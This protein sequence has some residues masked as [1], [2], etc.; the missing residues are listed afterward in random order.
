MSRKTTSTDAAVEKVLRYKAKTQEKKLNR[1]TSCREAIKDL[2]TFSI[3]PPNCRG[4]VEIAITNSL[5]ARQIARCRDCLKSVFQEG[6]KKNRYE[7]SQACNST[8]DPINILSSQNHL[9]TTIFKHIDPK[10]T[11]TH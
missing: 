9:S 6:K 10:N 5:R 7:C 8:K 11:H 2:G 3:N 4:F 1:S